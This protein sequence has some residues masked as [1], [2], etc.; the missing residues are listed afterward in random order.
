MAS[1]G[2]DAR[3]ARFVRAPRVLDSD[4]V[5]L[6]EQLSQSRGR[7]A[8]RDRRVALDRVLPQPLAQLTEPHA[9]H[10]PAPQHDGSIR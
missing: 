10:V 6:F 8:E 4:V 1:C 3:G 2:D 7:V 5:F 9:I